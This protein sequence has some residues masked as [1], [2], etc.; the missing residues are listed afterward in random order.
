M[1]FTTQVT[2]DGCIVRDDRGNFVI[3]LATEDEAFE[4][5]KDNADRY[6]REEPIKISL[7]D[8]FIYYCNKLP[9]KCFLDRRMATTNEKA[10][11][12]F[13]KSFEKARNAKVIYD[14]D[15]VG[16]EYFFIVT[17]VIEQ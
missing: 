1:D 12:K 15:F 2:Q 11:K 9:G 14:V 8:Q 3:E 4:W 6:V 10:L 5:I 13:I 7:E 16:G 17:D